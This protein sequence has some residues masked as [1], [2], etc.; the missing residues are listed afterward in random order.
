M[1]RCDLPAWA[2]LL[3]G[4]LCGNGAAMAQPVPVPPPPAPAC[5]QPADLP[6][7]RLYGLWHLTLWPLDGET[8]APVSRG[9]VLF[10]RHPE[11]PGSVR[12][13]LR[14]SAPGNERQAFVSGDVVD[15]EFHLDESA[16]GVTMDAVWTGTPQDCGQAL[17]GVRRPAEGRPA[18]G[19]AL[20]FLL[21]KAPGWR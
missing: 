14:R 3:A 11:Y 8:G 18:D 21:K 7:A 16:D 20:N 6:P 15:G 9:T 19:P 1:S 13:S 12:G 5:A 4:L 2:T 10:E 17:R